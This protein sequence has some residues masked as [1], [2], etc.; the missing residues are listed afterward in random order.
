MP[1]NAA[2]GRPKK[3][4]LIV[5]DDV[6]IAMAE[7]RA[8]ERIGYRTLIA[9]NAGK[10]IRLATEAGD[11][12]DLILMD[13]DL[14]TGIDGSEAAQ[15][16]LALRALPII[17]LTSHAEQEMVASVRG[18]T[19]YGYVTKDSG[20]FVLASSVEMAFDLFEAHAE[21]ANLLADKELLLKEVHHRIKNNL[22]LL[23]SLMSL[24]AEGMKSSE[25][26][27]ALRD[28]QSRIQSMGVLYDRLYRS[29]TF[30]DVPFKAFLASLIREIVS[31]FSTRAA[32]RTITRLDDFAID[33]K[34]SIPLAIIV[35]ELLINA[36]RHAFGDRE[37]GLI[38]VTGSRKERRV[39]LVVQDNGPGWPGLETGECARGFGL[40]LVGLL[41]GQIG[42]TFTMENRRGLRCTLTF[43]IG[44]S[45]AGREPPRRASSRAPG[46]ETTP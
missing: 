1:E 31:V 26:A 13:I 21:I 5:D 3:T 15:R 37:E 35:N 6:L 23:E 18:I 4:I 33:T 39:T 20:D 30:K 2:A 43:D 7:A 16:I 11:P 9:S 42:G 25:A 14:G 40:M 12:V 22:S 38:R 19:R 46:K 36:L 8:L 34:I 17:F 44:E 10:A 32:V 29:K 41:A 27:T 28:A 24:Q 45:G